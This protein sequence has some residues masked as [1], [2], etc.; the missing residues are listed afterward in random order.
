[1]YNTSM[2]SHH[3][4]ITRIN[5]YYNILINVT[6]CLLHR[7]RQIHRNCAKDIDVHLNIHNQQQ[8]YLLDHLIV[9]LFLGAPFPYA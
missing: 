2:T 4:K 8:T 1:M 3:P 7:N 9:I 5:G 6:F